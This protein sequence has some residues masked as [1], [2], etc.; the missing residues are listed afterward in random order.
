[1]RRQFIAAQKARTGRRAACAL[2][3]AI[4]AT[5]C[6]Q[7][8]SSEK[9][10]VVDNRTSYDLHFSVLLDQ[11]WYAPVGRA[12]PHQSAVI[13]GPEILPASGCTTGGMIALAEDGREV[14]RHDAPLCAGDRWVIDISSPSPTVSGSR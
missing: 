3:L 14:S 7:P 10:V 6:D 8:L 12:H 2:L 5:G 13:L 9:G 11:V 4:L 1:M